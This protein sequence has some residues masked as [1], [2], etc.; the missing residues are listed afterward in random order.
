MKLSGE[1]AERGD[2]AEFPNGSDLEA[3]HRRKP[4]RAFVVNQHGEV[5]L[6]T[7]KHGEES[8]SSD[9]SRIVHM[10]M[11]RAPKETHIFLARTHKE[12]VQMTPLNGSFEQPHSLVL[13]MPY[14]KSGTIRTQLRGKGLTK[15]ESEVVQMLAQGLS[16]REIAL[17][18]NVAPS[19]V[20][21]H[22]K[23]AM[24]K[25]NAH[26]RVELIVKATGGDEISLRAVS[27]S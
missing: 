10:L 25:M 3:I 18:L 24:S 20:V 12:V 27:R 17:G 15:R 19:T 1:G 8:M 26:G 6:G 23:G 14:R 21:Q 4:P 13:V 22:I 11:S 5:V 2:F 9:I 16:T 7:D